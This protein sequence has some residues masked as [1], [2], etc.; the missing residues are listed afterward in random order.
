MSKRDKLIWRFLTL[1]KDFTWAELKALLEC[2]GF[3]ESNAG[4]TSGSR[5][6]FYQ[7]NYTP[8]MIHKPHPG[9]IL[10]H[11][12]LKYIKEYLQNEGFL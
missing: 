4:K 3:E 12:Q 7:E 1:P 9:K 8:V 10:K 11:Y 6:R 5:V 2:F